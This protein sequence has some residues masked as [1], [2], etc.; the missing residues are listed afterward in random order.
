[1]ELKE[2][3]YTIFVSEYN[4][5]FGEVIWEKAKRGFISQKKEDFTWMEKLYFIKNTTS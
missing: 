1:M 4:F 3:G 2:K 5:P